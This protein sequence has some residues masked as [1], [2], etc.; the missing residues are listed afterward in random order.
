MTRSRFAVCALPLR[1]G[2]GSAALALVTPASLGQS[3]TFQGL[4]LPMFSVSARAHAVS[5]DGSTVT[6]EA[7]YAGGTRA[8]RWTQAGGMQVLDVLPGYLDGVGTGVSADG[9][10]VVG[11]CHDH[12]PTPGAGRAFR[13]TA[14][15]GTED[16]G[17]LPGGSASQALAI[18][19]DGAVIAGAGWNLLGLRAIRWTAAGIEEIVTP[20]T[21]VAE[22]V[23]ADGVVVGGWG[24][25]WTVAGG[26]EP[27]AGISFHTLNADGTAGAGTAS[28]EALRW[29]RTGGVHS[30]SNLGGGAG[31]TA[32]AISANGAMVVGSS[33]PPGP[34]PIGTFSPHAYLWTS[35]SG[36]K[37]LNVYLPALGANLAGAKLMMA[38]GL[39][40]DGRT[41]AGSG[42]MSTPGGEALQPW[43]ADIC[44]PDCDGNTQLTVADFVC[45][46]TRF[47]AVHPYADCN[48]DGALTVADFSCF[49]TAFVAGCP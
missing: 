19:A 29:T 48:A 17:V 7:K 30:L 44:Y 25:L 3:A 9:A 13:W 21:G 4:G 27:I 28:A 43:I 2:A 38:E 26:Y 45:F 11:F 23:S 40:A 41:I 47:V 49:Q 36:M 32:D 35:T 20:G 14:A 18:S 6:G 5:A 33:P 42:L 12:S 39:S 24:F 15:G 46:Q 10:I 16:L 34:L 8:F 22:A 31:S 37:D 1:I